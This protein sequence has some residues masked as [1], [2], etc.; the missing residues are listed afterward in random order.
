MKDT[1]AERVGMNYE[2][3][4]DAGECLI[5][6][7][8]QRKEILTCRVC[9]FPISTPWHISGYKC[10][11]TDRD[12]GVGGNGLELTIAQYFHCLTDNRHNLKSL[13]N[14]KIEVT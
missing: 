10:D 3:Q 12:R 1:A 9:Q 11:S 13:N 6:F 7:F 2:Y 4:R 5:P 14:S 8:L